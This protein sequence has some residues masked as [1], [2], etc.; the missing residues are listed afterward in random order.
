MVVAKGWREGEMG[1][2]LMGIEFSFVRWKCSGDW[3]YNNVNI[4]LK[5][6]QQAQNGVAY[7]KPHVI[8][9][10]LDLQFCLFQ[11][12]NLKLANWELPNSYPLGNL[13]DR[14]IS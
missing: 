5:T 8:K 7:P 6:R 14:P 3:L 11:K 4:L 1:S 13:P 12:W 10:K 9:P 2:C